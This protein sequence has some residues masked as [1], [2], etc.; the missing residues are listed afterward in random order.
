MKWYYSH[1]VML[2][3]TYVCIALGSSIKGLNSCGG[4]KGLSW[5]VIN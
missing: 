2:L 5:N 3:G 1:D 4:A